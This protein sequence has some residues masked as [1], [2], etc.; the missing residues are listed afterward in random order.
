ME[1]HGHSVAY[2]TVVAFDMMSLVRMV[3]RKV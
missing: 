2:S 3:P 1:M